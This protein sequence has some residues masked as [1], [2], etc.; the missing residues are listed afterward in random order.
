MNIH[1]S[2]KSYER[3]EMLISLIEEIEIF[4]KKNKSHNVS[5]HIIDDCSKFSN[6]FVKSNKIIQTEKNYG[7]K[8]HWKLWDMDFGIL[9][10][11]KQIDLFI[12]LPSDASKVNFNEIIKQSELLKEQEYIF[13]I[14]NDGRTQCWNRIKPEIVNHIYMKIGFVDCCFFTNRMTLDKLGFFMLEIDKS[15]FLLNKNISS[16][17]GEQLTRRINNEKIDIFLPY[18][19]FI[20]HGDHESTMHKEERKKNPLVSAIKSKLN[21][22]IY[23]GIAT[24]KGREE[25]LKKTLESLN[26][27]SLKPTKIFVYNNAT[28]K[29][30]YTDNAKFHALSQIKG[31][32]Y[33]LSC[34]DDLEYSPTYIQDMVNAIIKHKCIVTHHGRILQGLSRN[35]FRGHKS[36][37][38]LGDNREECFIDVAGTG[39]TAFDTSYFNDKTLYKAQDKR[40]SDLVFSLRVAREKKKI[41][42]L[43]HNGNYIKQ[44][45]IDHSTSCHTIE[46]VNPVVQNQIADEIFILNH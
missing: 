9:G 41:M 19:S 6:E 24:M 4:L 36:F 15:R 14:S 20:F 18:N 21:K 22:P 38:C 16:G 32:C 37:R 34:D 29:V 7:K 33:Y 28:E 12:F 30:D 10:R 45:P 17:V 26:N 43:R 31:H 39:V 13:N 5:Y 3:K 25:S 46:S 2:V 35:Y 1:I 42:V 11:E 44:L 27:Q 40:M 8:L 23:I